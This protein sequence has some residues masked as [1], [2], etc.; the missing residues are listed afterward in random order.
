[1]TNYS[2]L[3]YGAVGD[4]VAV[5]TAAIQKA[6]DTCAAK[7]GGTVF[8]PPGRYLCGS[9]DLASNLNLHLENGAK[10]ICHL[11]VDDLKRDEEFKKKGSFYL[12]AAIGCTGV[13]VSGY[14]EIDGQ[15][16]LAREEDDGKSEYPLLPDFTAR[17]NT[18]YFRGCENVSIHNVTLRDASAWTIHLIGCRHVDI[19]G[20]KILNCLRGANNDGIDPDSCR[21][22]TIRGCYVE[23]GDDA[24]VLKTTKPAAE[25]YGPCEDI[26][27]T[28]CTLISRGSAV[29]IG[30][31]TWADIRRV[32]FTDCI[33][34]ESNRGLGIWVR[35]GGTV[36]DIMVS[37]LIIQTRM[38]G[39]AYFRTVT[40]DWWGKGE[41]IF[42]SAGYRF[43]GKPQYPG[44]IR[45]IRAS[46]ITAACENSIFIKGC[47]ESEIEDILLE[48]IQLR[49]E[50][51]SG[52]QLGQFDEQPPELGDS[53]YR[54]NSPGIYLHRCKRCEVD[55][56]RVD[57]G[58]KP[59]AEWSHLLEC[60]ES[61][62]LTFRRICGEAAHEGLDR[63]KVTAS[64][65]IS[66]E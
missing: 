48:N 59:E 27:V 21:D 12:F 58:E 31:E 24:I 18:F 60:V 26:L 56:L 40:P 52:E 7:G 11:T 22:V 47:P 20:V 34:K 25:R 28:G 54:H 49:F 41:P 44:K 45:R 33:V 53:V 55:G 9:V 4:G 1:M 62:G 30:T 15:G 6:V 19:S 51:R 10:I 16:I 37:N 61:S 57:W 5:D 8:F 42:L 63:V 17:A 32:M 29:K 3:D 14:G 65:G 36:E 35:D 50:R 23:G 39:G 13:S 46:G 38:W 64:E 2:V 43:H 66:I